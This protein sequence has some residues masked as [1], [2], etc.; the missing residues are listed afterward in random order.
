MRLLHEKINMFEMVVG[1]L[2][3]ILTPLHLNR[4]F[5]SRLIDIFV[6]SETDKDLAREF[7]HLGETIL[8]A[9]T[10][11]RKPSILGLLP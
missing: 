3:A 5:E 7:D 1:E 8:K 2:D 9:R 10:L 4:S 6:R 11:Q